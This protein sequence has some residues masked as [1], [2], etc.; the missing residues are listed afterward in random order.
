MPAR[1]GG[2]GQQRREPL[3]PPIDDVVDL[4]AAFGEE[5]LDVAVGQAAAQ[6]PADASTIPSGGKRKPARLERG[7]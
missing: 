7:G 2:V 6:I 1:P 4:N 5:L 3:D